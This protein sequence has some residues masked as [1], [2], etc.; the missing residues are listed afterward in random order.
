MIDADRFTLVQPAGLGNGIEKL[1]AP[2]R[3][4]RLLQGLDLPMIIN[5]HHHH[6]A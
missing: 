6:E 5:H 4:P 2:R 1:L 3:F